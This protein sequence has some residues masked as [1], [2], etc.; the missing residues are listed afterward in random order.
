MMLSLDPVSRVDE[1]RD[2]KPIEIRMY[3][4][5]WEHNRDCLG[6]HGLCDLW[7][8]EISPFITLKNIFVYGIDCTSLYFFLRMLIIIK[9]RG[10]QC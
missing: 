1:I 5:A 10:K 3:D 6:F 4:L 8:R 7:F 2:L 9:R